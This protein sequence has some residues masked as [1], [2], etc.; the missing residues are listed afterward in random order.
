VLQ[1]LQKFSGPVA[2]AATGPA[3]KNNVKRRHYIF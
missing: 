2:Q 3:I 1:R